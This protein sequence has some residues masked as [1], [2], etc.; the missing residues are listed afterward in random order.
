[1]GVEALPRDGMRI[2][3]HHNVLLPETRIGALIHVDG[4]ELLSRSEAN[5][6][7]TRFISQRT[8]WRE[9]HGNANST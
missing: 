4:L 2:M 7:Q 9:P 8:P 1:M 5:W 3:V 6:R